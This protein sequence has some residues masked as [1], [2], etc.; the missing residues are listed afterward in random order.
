MINV[1]YDIL[2]NGARNFG[3][4]TAVADVS[5]AVSFSEL[6]EKADNYAGKLRA[7]GIGNG[8]IV[9]IFG[10]NS[11]EWVAVM[12]AVVKAGAVAALINYSM[13]E[14]DLADLIKRNNIKYV[15]YG[16]NRMMEK[17]V[18]A[19]DHVIAQ[20]GI[21][22]ENIIP[23]ERFNIVE[24]SEECLPDG[25]PDDFSVIIFTSGTT[26]APK[27]CMQTQHALIYGASST[28]YLLEDVNNIGVCVCAPV[29]HLLGFSHLLSGLMFGSTV[30]LPEKMK[31]E[32]LFP[33]IEEYKTGMI[34][35]VPTVLISLIE[36]PR[37]DNIAS[38]CVKGFLSAGG[39][40]S[41]VQIQKLETSCDKAVCLNAYGSSEAG[42][43]CSTTY[44]SPLEIR[45]HSLGPVAR[46]KQVAILDSEN[47][48]LPAMEM[49]E[50]CI[51]KTDSVMLGYLG[52][53]NEEVFDA[54]GWFHSGDLGYID[55]D[56]N[57]FLS[58]RIKDLIIKGG[59]N[60]SPSEV[61]KAILEIEGI[62]LCKVLGAPSR[63]YGET[64]EAC[65]VLKS[66]ANLTEEDIRNGL[67][68]K[69]N[70]FKTPEHVL[71]F[72]EF[73]LNTNGKIDVKALKVQAL[74][75]LRKLF[76]EHHLDEGMP[77]GSLHIA[78]IC[79]GITPV[80]IFIAELV[81][82]IGIKKDA[83]KIQLFTEEM[84]TERIINNG[85]DS[86]Y[87]D[88]RV[89]L[90]R[91]FLRI[92]LEDRGELY[93]FEKRISENNLSARIIYKC[94]DDMDYIRN[95]DVNTFLAD[96]RYESSYE[97]VISSLAAENSDFAE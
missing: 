56:G 13:T 93:D 16:K 89:E 73:P 85:V 12:F 30:C 84:L 88:I 51:K 83:G 27:A 87:I 60:I 42:F 2:E 14:P 4:R 52:K 35:G 66:G 38:H 74:T 3:D 26:S 8:D 40:I 71:F 63:L 65:V 21:S 29:Y 90:F 64:V 39:C 68:G 41:P 10:Y 44:K 23:F 91:D 96:F 86:G 22:A 80:A 1:F 59:E 55:G 15:L 28:Q 61:E 9:G 53:N 47:R 92:R 5:G 43:I 77:L 24:K 48:E 18:S 17:D 7:M 95:K 79:R 6:K 11:I 37:F 62:S 76:I 32:N 36:D 75:T 34:V 19:F 72:D 67:K 33:F 82:N 46:G 54:D 25:K 94:V 45:L 69:I 50:I 31:S 49:G 97:A 78:N 70:S 58:G 20:S 81:R 57:V